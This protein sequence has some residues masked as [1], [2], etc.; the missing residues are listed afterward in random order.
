MANNSK[1]LFI[2]VFLGL[3]N[4]NCFAGSKSSLNLSNETFEIK[5]ADC[6]I[7]GPEQRIL[8]IKE[9][10]SSKFSIPGGSIIENETPEQGAKRETW[11]ETG[12]SV[13]VG[14]Q[15]AQ[16]YNSALF[17]CTLEEPVPYYI[18]KMGRYIV[19][20][21]SFPH[22]GKEV[23]NVQWIQDDQYMRDNY[24]FPEH[25]W[26]FS[27]WIKKLAQ[28]PS[29]LVNETAQ[30]HISSFYQNQINISNQIKSFFLNQEQEDIIWQS[31][32]FSFLAPALFVLFSWIYIRSFYGYRA[33]FNYAIY[34]VPLYAL[35]AI[36]ISELPMPRPYFFSSSFNVTDHFGYSFPN[37]LLILSSFFFLWL[38]KNTKQK[39]KVL[40]YLISLILSFFIISLNA[41]LSGA[42]FI[43][44]ILFG[45]FF[46][47]AWFYLYKN[48]EK[49]YSINNNK[50][51]HIIW[52]LFSVT[53]AIVG[54]VIHQ[55]QLIFLCAFSFG[56]YC[57]IV[58][59]H[60]WPRYISFFHYKAKIL[61][62]IFSSLALWSLFMLI[63][64]VTQKT[65]V[66]EMIIL[67]WTIFYFIS[68]FCLLVIFP[69]WYFNK[70]NTSS[71]FS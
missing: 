11:E 21:W 43:S 60:F 63:D 54:L 7:L 27:T 1:W 31:H 20:N 46:V 6:L 42:N 55:P 47:I 8:M 5:A 50:M 14:E 29:Y 40:F 32:V 65:A 4:F 67:D 41:I 62:F 17:S 34:S 71:F 24:R 28:S 13:I 36:M 33:S 12:L 44:D 68:P 51:N 66:N 15:I 25:K 45:L 2:L 64:T 69:R 48:T 10:L 3:I 30:Q 52:I 56:I 9:T 35:T 59:Q 37:Q 26:M 39:I 18:D 61:F 49:H 19:M 38:M 70:K 22:F 57:A 53:W 23:I 58:C 16:T